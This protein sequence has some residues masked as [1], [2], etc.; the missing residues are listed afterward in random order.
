MLHTVA[1]VFDEIGA[2]KTVFFRVDRVADLSC[3]ADG[4]LL[5]PAFCAYGMTSFERVETAQ[6]D[7][8]I[9]QSE[10]YTRVAHVLIQVGSG[11]QGKADAREVGA[12]TDRRSTCCLR[13]CLWIVE[14][15][16]V[17]AL[18]T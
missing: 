5:I 7:V 3:V 13:E 11:T 12:P 2:E 8:Q 14:A 6:T 4:N 9:R 1:P 16:Q 18:I 15:S 17:V 10:R